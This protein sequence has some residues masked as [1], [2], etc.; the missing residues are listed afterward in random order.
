MYLG[1]GSDAERM[2]MQG[3]EGGSVFISAAVT[4]LITSLSSSLQTNGRAK[5]P[6]RE[7]YQRDDIQNEE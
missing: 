7:T 1:R 4:R 5:T 6:G 2:L 3:V